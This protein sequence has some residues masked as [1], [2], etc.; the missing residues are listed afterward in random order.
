MKFSLGPVQYFWPKD[1]MLQF[2][3]E[4]ADSD[5]DIVYLGETVCSK[6]RE[7]KFDDYFAIAKTLH[8]AGKQV[9][10]SSMT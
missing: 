7:L 9:C 8:E 3:R 4:V 6:R 1:Q 2:Y 5:F 10:L